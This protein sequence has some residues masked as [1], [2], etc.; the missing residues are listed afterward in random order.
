MLGNNRYGRMD[1]LLRA[2]LAVLAG[3]KIVVMKDLCAQPSR[4]IS[5]SL[6][7]RRN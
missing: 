3:G 4:F 7:F 1:S 6:L 2:V 5:V